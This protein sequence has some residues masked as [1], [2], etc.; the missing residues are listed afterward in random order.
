MGIILRNPKQQGHRAFGFSQSQHFLSYQA[1]TVIQEGLV[2]LLS[3][4]HPM[5]DL[6]GSGRY[7]E[8]S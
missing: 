7:L 8:T 6:A 5:A 2:K 1:H 3:D 4:T